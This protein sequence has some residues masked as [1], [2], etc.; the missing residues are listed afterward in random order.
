MCLT[1][2]L[3]MLRGGGAKK[4]EDTTK[5]SRCGVVAALTPLC[6]VALPCPRCACA[7]SRI[8][9]RA[10]CCPSHVSPLRRVQGRRCR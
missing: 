4:A 8:H 1:Q 2:I 7:C 3:K 10:H 6:D 9:C 5:Y